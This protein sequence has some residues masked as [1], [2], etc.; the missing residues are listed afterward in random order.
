MAVSD[1]SLMVYAVCREAFKADGG[2]RCSASPS[3]RCVTFNLPAFARVVAKEVKAEEAAE[4][5][6]VAL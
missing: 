5:E 6:A 2:R 4:A 3:Q 1:R